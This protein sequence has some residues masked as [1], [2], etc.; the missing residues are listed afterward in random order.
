[1][2]LAV[3]A[4]GKV[5]T[6]LGLAGASGATAAAT[7]AGTV[8]GGAAAGSG[9]LGALQGIATTLK[10]LGGIGAGIAAR[11]QAEDAPGHEAVAVR[12]VRL[13]A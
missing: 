5:F 7:T 8:A 3:A 12:Y 10:V 9:A 1:M 13:A 6:G 11:N 4:L 2:E